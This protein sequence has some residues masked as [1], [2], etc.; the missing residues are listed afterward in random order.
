[1]IEPYGIRTCNGT[2]WFH[3][4]EEGYMRAFTTMYLT[5][6]NMLAKQLALPKYPEHELLG[7][8]NRIAYIIKTV[9]AANHITSGKT[10]ATMFLDMAY[11]GKLEGITPQVPREPVEQVLEKFQSE[12]PNIWGVACDELGLSAS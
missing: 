1:M 12:W 10:M 7:E 2:T 11:K 9:A 3:I 4:P 5:L 8:A 6:S